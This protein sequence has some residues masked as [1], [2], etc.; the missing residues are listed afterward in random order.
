MK[1]KAAFV[2]SPQALRRVKYLLSQYKPKQSNHYNNSSDARNA[3]DKKTNTTT[4]PNAN[5]E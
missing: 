5:T 1:N 4:T 3:G 2:L